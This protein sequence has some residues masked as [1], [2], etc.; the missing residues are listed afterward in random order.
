MKRTLI[1]L[2]TAGTVAAVAIFA[3]GAFFQDTETSS[4]NI[5]TAGSIDLGID[6][7]SYYNGLPNP[8]TTWRV[9]YDLSDNPARQFFNF[10]D[11]KPG[12]WGEDT[13]SLH[14]RDNNSWLCADVTLTRDDD[15]GLVEPE[16]DDG[17]T[18]DGPGNGELADH[19]N[20]YWWADD[21]DNVFETDERLLPSGPL[22]ALSVGQTATVA[23]A[24][25]VTNIWTNLPEDPLTPEDVRFVAKAWCFGNTTMTPY[26]QDE[27]NRQNGPD[28]RPVICDGSQET[29]VTQSDSLTA[30]IS[31]RAVQSRNNGGFLCNPPV[32][33]V[34]PEPIGVPE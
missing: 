10:T 25:S 1:G 14:V 23:L 18:T 7:H 11:V 2:M 27:G 15:N 28:D 33:T 19:I 4:D 3:T 26:E 24:D 32:P 12:D 20:F 9:D 13:I 34:T 21:G 17:D 16:V 29:N 31:F 22:G 5:F 8:G 30:D 6:N